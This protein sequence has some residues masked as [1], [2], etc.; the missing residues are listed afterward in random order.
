MG[1][2]GGNLTIALRVQAFSR[3]LKT[4][5]VERLSYIWTNTA[6]LLQTRAMKHETTAVFTPTADG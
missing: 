3:K 4:P 6:T 1:G 5:R 2:G